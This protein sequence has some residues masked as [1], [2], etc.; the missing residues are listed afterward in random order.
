MPADTETKEL[1]DELKATWEGGFKEVHAKLEAEEKQRGE[2]TAETK[3]ELEK[4]QKRLDDLEI[5]LQKAA[6]R[7]GQK[8]DESAPSESKRLFLDWCRKGDAA[9]RGYEEKTEGGE[10]ALYNT[11]G[12]KVLVV[13]QDP[14][15]GYL[16]P[17]EF[18]REI[19]KGVQL[20]SPIRR[21][22]GVR[23]TS[24]RS[25]QIP[26]RTGVFSAVWVGE[27]STRS[28]TTGLQYGLE[29]IPAHEMYALVDISN[30]DL[31]DSVFDLEAELNSEFATQFAK[32]EGSAFV[33]GNAVGKPEGLLTNASIGTVNSGSSGAVTADGLFSLSGSLKSDYVEGSY[34]AL[35]RATLYAVR[36][37]KDSQNRYLWEPSMQ[38]GLPNAI[39]GIPY[40][41]TPDMPDLASGSKSI[42]LGNF[43]RGYVIVDRVAMSL[44][45]DPYT[46]ATAGATRF[47]ARKR[48]G[49]QTVLPEAFK[50]QVAS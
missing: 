42:I 30:Q 19:I 41:E 35:N 23:Q 10:K 49:G 39:D 22:A 2:A 31:E 45:R 46:Q 9:L 25:T 36:K 32:A 16:A 13:Q 27:T 26:K 15:G 21:V 1:F 11:D 38:S 6:E 33:S 28:E 29:E 34:W 17:P 3:A 12:E 8:Q 18:V 47:I 20:I 7:I 14:T 24:S 4:T 43:K 50:I 40:I 5:T 37:L 48:V 44:Q